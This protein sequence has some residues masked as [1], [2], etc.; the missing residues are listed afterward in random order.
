MAGVSGVNAVT[1]T[2]QASSIKDVLGKNE[3]L[4]LLA[5]QLKY[6]NPLEPLN[7]AEFMGQMAQFTTVEQI[8]NLSNAFSE[9]NSNIFRTQ[10][11]ALLNRKVE[12]SLGTQIV[13][14]TVTK[15]KFEGGSAKLT[16]TNPQGAT[17]VDIANLISASVE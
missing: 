10:S 16:V 13:A 17:E 2:Q 9:F 1:T 12:A 11:I 15:V 4:K 6:Q 7:D 3:F 14:G 5:T 8:A